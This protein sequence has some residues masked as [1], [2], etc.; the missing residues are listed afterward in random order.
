LTG[1]EKTIT[2]L[3][4]T[5]IL[6][7]I[8]AMPHMLKWIAVGLVA[9]AAVLIFGSSGSA[10]PTTGESGTPQRQHVTTYPNGGGDGPP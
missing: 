3:G 9:L 7:G 8:R 1:Y 10:K 2:L 5:P 4:T 6:R